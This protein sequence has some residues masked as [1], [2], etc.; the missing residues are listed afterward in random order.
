MIIFSLILAIRNIKNQHN[1]LLILMILGMSISMF[2]ILSE[3]LKSSNYIISTIYLPNKIEY[4]LFLIISN[5][6]RLTLSHLLILRNT[7][8]II[9]LIAIILFSINFNKS[10]MI[11]IFLIV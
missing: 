6:F 10:L 11:N 5:F 1:L 7:G 9:Y 8:I 4:H 3:I 2:T